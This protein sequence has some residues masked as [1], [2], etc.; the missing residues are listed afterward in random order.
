MADKIDNYVDGDEFHSSPH[1]IY[2][3]ESDSS[4]YFKYSNKMSKVV[5]RP[6]HSN[7]SFSLDDPKHGR[8]ENFC[9]WITSEQPGTAEKFSFNQNLN[10]ILESYLGPGDSIGWHEHYDTEEYYYV[11]EGEM[12]VECS[13]AQGHTFSAKL[14]VGDLHRLSCGMS[15]YAKAGPD[16][17]KFLAVIIKAV[18]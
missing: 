12:W 15:H 1:S 7:P 3:C 9:K 2:S 17:A 18:M 10:G 16:G 6:A 8:G 5:Y 4:P 13:D 11:L 14:G